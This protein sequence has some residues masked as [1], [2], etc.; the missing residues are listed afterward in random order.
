MIGLA[1]ILLPIG[2]MVPERVSSVSV[3]A[4]STTTHTATAP[5]TA[6][7][8]ATRTPT[9][10]PTRTATRT[11]TPTNTSTPTCTQTPTLTSTRSAIATRPPT[12]TRVPTKTPPP[13]P[14]LIPTVSAA[15]GFAV[16]DSVMLGAARALQHVFPGLTVDAQ[17][18]R[19]LGVATDVLRRRRSSG[20]IDQFVIIH[21]GDN[22]YF[23]PEQFEALLQLV[24][25]VPHVIV[26]NLKEPRAWEAANNAVIADVVRRY[27]NAVLVDW[28]SASNDHP[29][30]FARDG[31]HLG[32][33]GALAYTQL[34]VEQL[35]PLLSAAASPDQNTN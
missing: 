35:A 8:T 18:S 10:T 2:S 33:K 14:T 9:Y 30:Y 34:I 29:E 22:G 32:T 16:G 11:S 21:I 26:F 1:V 7:S 28:H 15:T 31:I 3:T 24:K 6:T 23:K 5:A 12:R 4:T 25:D 19:H 17:V 27:P 13:T 20:V